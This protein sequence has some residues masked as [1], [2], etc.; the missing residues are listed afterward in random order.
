MACE[1]AMLITLALLVIGGLIAFA[2]Y[3][4]TRGEESIVAGSGNAFDAY[5]GKDRWDP[6]QSPPCDECVGLGCIGAGECR[7]Y[8]HR[9]HPRKKKK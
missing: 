3:S 2:L 4:S 7:C 5:Y 6:G 1:N 8:C 9:A